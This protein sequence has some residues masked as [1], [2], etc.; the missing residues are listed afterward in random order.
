M[1]RILAQFDKLTCQR[2]LSSSVLTAVSAWALP[3]SPG[4]FS[5]FDLFSCLNGQAT[6]TLL[7]HMSMDHFLMA[8]SRCC[9]CTLSCA[10]AAQYTLL[11]A[12]RDPNRV[13]F[14]IKTL[15]VYFFKAAYI[16]TL[17]HVHIEATC[18]AI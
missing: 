7:P 11:L 6:M 16:T 13:S 4:L 17:A 15:P 2:M 14:V 3:S 9:K 1:H 10:Y 12:G 5:G 8:Q 18:H